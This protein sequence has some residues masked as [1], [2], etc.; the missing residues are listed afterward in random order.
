[1]ALYPV[2]GTHFAQGAKAV[3]KIV[4]IVVIDSPSGQYAW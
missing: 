1:M 4:T 3:A 2:K